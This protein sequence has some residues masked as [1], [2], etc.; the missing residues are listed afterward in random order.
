MQRPSEL[1]APNSGGD[2]VDDEDKGHTNGDLLRI[3]IDILINGYNQI[4]SH[5]QLLH[6]QSIALATLFIPVLLWVAEILPGSPQTSYFVAFAPLIMAAVLGSLIYIR[7]AS[8][9]YM[10]VCRGI[11]RR[12][13]ELIGDETLFQWEHVQRKRFDDTCFSRWGPGRI[14]YILMGTMSVLVYVYLSFRSCVFLADRLSHFA[15]KWAIVLGACA[16][17]GTAVALLGLSVYK[18]VRIWRTNVGL[19]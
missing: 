5:I 10:H 8:L 15:P 9:I 1:P 2:I 14:M 18:T 6:R 12:I 13:N 4:R 3:K 11:E 17:Y 19:K 16:V 7:T